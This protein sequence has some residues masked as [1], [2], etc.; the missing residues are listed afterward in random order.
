MPFN[1]SASLV[2]GMHAEGYALSTKFV[3]EQEQ[4]GYRLNSAPWI[5]YFFLL[6]L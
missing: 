6:F 1:S 4:R 3:D 5:N 2:L